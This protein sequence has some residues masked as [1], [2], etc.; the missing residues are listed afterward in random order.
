MIDTR[1]VAQ[2]V[3]DQLTAAMHRGQEQLRKGQEQ[4]RKGRQTVTGAL[5]TG[6]HIA[7]AVKPNLPALPG[8]SLKW[9]W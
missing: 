4:V 5:R 2:E 7:Q 9:L 3:Q 6:G 1:A 8:P